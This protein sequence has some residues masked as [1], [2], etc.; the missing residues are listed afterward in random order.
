MLRVF[1]LLST[2]S[3]NPATLNSSRASRT[4]VQTLFRISHISSI[5]G[6]LFSLNSCARRPL[7]PDRL[8][9]WCVHQI[10]K[11]LEIEV[12]LPCVSLFIGGGEEPEVVSLIEPYRS[13]ITHWAPI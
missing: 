2:A 10:R 4:S 9:L 6:E 12:H 11:R 5:S 3:E 13:R 1:K 8:P 7:V